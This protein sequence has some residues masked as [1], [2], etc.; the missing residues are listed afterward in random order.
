MWMLKAFKYRLYPTKQ[1]EAALNEMLE[2][3]RRL[4]NHSLAERRD[5]WEKEGR[6]VNY[7][8][9]ANTLKERRKQDPYLARVN[10]SDPGCASPTGQGVQGIFPPCQSRR[11]AGLPTI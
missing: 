4:Y 3:C 6:S 7:Y 9:Q 11:E 8:D 5:A 2:T 10:F 1:Q